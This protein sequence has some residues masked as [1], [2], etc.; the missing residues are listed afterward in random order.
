MCR[1]GKKIGVSSQ[2]DYQKAEWYLQ[3]LIDRKDKLPMDLHSK[4][5]QDSPSKFFDV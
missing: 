1:A 5:L 2:E 4:I 3:R